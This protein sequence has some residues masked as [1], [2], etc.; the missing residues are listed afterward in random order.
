[1]RKSIV[2]SG[3]M[4]GVDLS[5]ANIATCNS[6]WYW[7][8]PLCWAYSRDAWTQAAALPPI[9]ASVVVAPKPP[10]DALTNPT[11]AYAPD[12]TVGQD[13]S[14]AAILATQGNLQDWAQTIPDNPIPD[15]PC[16]WMNI[17][18]TNW[19]IIAGGLG[20]FLLASWGNIFASRGQGVYR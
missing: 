3:G 6:G 15:V 18:C 2:N 5:P 16:Q 17:S 19:W 13:L 11:G 4:N 7:A 10:A 8:N 12:S 14:N 9:P 1:M 20:L